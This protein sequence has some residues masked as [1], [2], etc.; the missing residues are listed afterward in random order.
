VSFSL[1]TRSLPRSSVSLP[2]AASRSLVQFDV[3]N[4]PADVVSD[5]WQNSFI[6]DM[7]MEGVLEYARRTSEAPDLVKFKHL[8]ARVCRGVVYLRLV[9]DA[10]A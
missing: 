7:T 1:C 4:S 2:N 10:R 9:R 5:I 3:E 6:V 8:A